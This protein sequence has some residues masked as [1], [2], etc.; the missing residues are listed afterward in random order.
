MRRYLR[1]ACGGYRPGHDGGET[2]EFRLGVCFKRDPLFLYA[3]LVG[4]LN[5]N[6]L[7]NSWFAFDPQ[8]DNFFAEGSA[9]TKGS[10]TMFQAAVVDGLDW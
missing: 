4:S 8:K 9:A 10:L 7:G 2:D 6:L 1:W 5:F 3:Y